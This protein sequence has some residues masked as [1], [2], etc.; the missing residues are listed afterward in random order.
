M[1]LGIYAVM[2]AFLIALVVS[3]SGA[4]SAQD[5]GQSVTVSCIA[6]STRADGQELTADEIAGYDIRYADAKGVEQT[7]RSTDCNE[8][9]PGFLP[10]SYYFSVR[11]IDTDGLMSGWTEPADLTVNSAPGLPTG[12]TLTV[13]VTVNVTR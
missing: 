4:A 9:I 13:T 5:M 3:F 12:V 7:I 1:R 6:P 10:G 11:T 2:T 8:T